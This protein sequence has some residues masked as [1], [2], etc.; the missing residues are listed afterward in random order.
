MRKTASLLNNPLCSP[1]TGVFVLILAKIGLFRAFETP[2][3]VMFCY[4]LSPSV[5]FCCLLRQNRPETVVLCCLLL[6]SED[7]F[8]R[9]PKKPILSHYLYGERCSVRVS[10]PSAISSS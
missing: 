9:V 2:R 10:A 8:V 6:S 4:I 7:F 3:I 5:V 1:T